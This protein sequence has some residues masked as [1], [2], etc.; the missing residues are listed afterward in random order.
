MKNKKYLSFL[1]FHS[2]D[3]R[4]DSITCILWDF[5]CAAAMLHDSVP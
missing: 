3:A 5:V 1:V 2:I 4:P